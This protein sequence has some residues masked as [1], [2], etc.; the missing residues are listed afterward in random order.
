MRIFLMAFC[1]T[2]A[3][4]SLALGYEWQVFINMAGITCLLVSRANPRR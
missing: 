4:L 1:I 3:G 2:G